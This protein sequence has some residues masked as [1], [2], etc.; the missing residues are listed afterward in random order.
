MSM[1]TYEAMLDEKELDVKIAQAEAE[2]KVSCTLLDA[3]EALTTLR[4]KH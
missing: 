2:F 4:R 1:E 3:R